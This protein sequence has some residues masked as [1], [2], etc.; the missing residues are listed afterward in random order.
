MIFLAVTMGFFA[1]NIREQMVENSQGREY[2]RSLVEDLK[3][4]TAQY[5][6]LIARLK[7]TDSVT[8]DIFNCYDT[9]TH[10]A[11]S[12]ACLN[13]IVR[14]LVGFGD[15]VYTDRTMQQ[16]KNSGGLRLIKDKSAA[17]SIIT[18][19]ALVRGEL[20]HQDGLEI[21]QQKAIDAGEAIIDFI[22]FSKIYSSKAVPNNNIQLLQ[23]NKQAID[24]YFNQ[25]WVFKRNLYSQKVILQ[26]LKIKAAQLISF[27][28]DK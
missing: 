28:N 16:L 5:T 18:Y 23:N 11:R 2:I 22:S 17:D 26:R 7:Y 3:K 25:L 8:D 6:R 24:N 21:Y 19:D 12:A 4:D 13:N 27:L 14:N 9:I 1:E 15:F 20:I 10:N